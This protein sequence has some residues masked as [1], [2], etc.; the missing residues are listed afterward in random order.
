[1]LRIPVV[2][3]DVDLYRHLVDKYRTGTAA[4]GVGTN[5]PGTD[6]GLVLARNI[7]SG[8]YQ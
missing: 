8:R 7:R 1:M 3:S 4:A 5:R 6:A 2:D